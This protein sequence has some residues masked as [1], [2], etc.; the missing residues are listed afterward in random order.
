MT[1]VKSYM[2]GD[3]GG[4]FSSLAG[5]GKKV[6]GGNDSEEVRK[7]TKTSPADCIQWSGCKDSQTSADTSEAG[8][9]TGAMSYAFITALSTPLSLRPPSP[10]ILICAL[11]AAKYP[12]QTY[13]YLNSFFCT[14]SALTFVQATPQH[15]PRRASRQVRP[16]PSALLVRLFERLFQ[17]CVA[18]W[19]FLQLPRARLQ[20]RRNHVGGERGGLSRNFRLLLY[21]QFFQSGLV[22]LPREPRE[23]PSCSSNED[24]E[25]F[26]RGGVQLFQ[27]VVDGST[28]APP[29]LRVCPTPL[30]HRSPRLLPP[31]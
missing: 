17:S 30:P 20:P 19:C 14:F 18:N 12:Q 1:A 5:V 16:A 27:R 9:A 10:S 25:M 6:L 24:R 26:T 15:D 7:Q 21:C 22:L 8:K 23:A 11:L 13:M 29:R 28:R 31:P 2:R 3:L 4:V